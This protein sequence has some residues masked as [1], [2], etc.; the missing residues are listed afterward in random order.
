MDSPQHLPPSSSYYNRERSDGPWDGRTEQSRG[1]RDDPIRRHPT[2]LSAGSPP[3]YDRDGPRINHLATAA[4]LPE[5]RHPGGR[6]HTTTNNNR[7][8]TGARTTP[9]IPHPVAPT[10]TEAAAEWTQLLANHRPATTATTPRE[11]ATPT[12]VIVLPTGPESRMAMF[13]RGTGVGIFRKTPIAAGAVA[14]VRLVGATALKGGPS[15]GR[16]PPPALQGVTT[17]Q[18]CRGGWRAR[19]TRLQK[20]RRMCPRSNH[21]RWTGCDPRR[22]AAAMTGGPRAGRVPPHRPHLPLSAL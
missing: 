7:G 20:H 2:G 21:T 11:A 9:A 1:R 5:D 3:P 18:G 13:P 14:S 16:H 22:I 8:G 10:G 4:P 12:S 6:D 17:S 15:A 19:D